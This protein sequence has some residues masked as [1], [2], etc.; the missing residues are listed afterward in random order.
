MGACAGREEHLRIEDDFAYLVHKAP[1]A[2]FG[3]I[4]N[5]FVPFY[6]EAPA[7][8]MRKTCCFYFQ[9]STSGEYCTVCPKAK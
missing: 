6:T 9:V 1:G 8:R 7:V 3:E 4:Q 2:L 5:P